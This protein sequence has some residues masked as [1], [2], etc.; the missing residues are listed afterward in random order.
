MTTEKKPGQAGQPG[1]QSDQ[2]G[3]KIDP[4]QAGNKPGSQPG[5]NPQKPMDKPAR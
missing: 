5:Q 3:Q 4:S 1:H 2:P